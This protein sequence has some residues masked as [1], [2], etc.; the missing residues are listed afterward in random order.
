[1]N[2]QEPLERGLVDRTGLLSLTG[3]TGHSLGQHSLRC[4]SLAIVHLG[5][6]LKI[7]VIL[8]GGSGLGQWPQV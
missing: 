6:P 5:R 4:P 7:E 3:G 8:I 2:Q 1:M